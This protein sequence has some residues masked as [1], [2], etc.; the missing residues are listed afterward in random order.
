MSGVKTYYKPTQ[1]RGKRVI[2]ASIDPAELRRQ[3][4][5]GWIVV[6]TFA[7]AILVIAWLTR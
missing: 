4:V 7:V 5:I 1:M 6:P 2:F 3:T